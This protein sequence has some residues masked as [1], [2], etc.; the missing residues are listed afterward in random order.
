MKKFSIILLVAL[1]VFNRIGAQDNNQ[2]LQ[3]ANQAFEMGHFSQADTILLS[4][5]KQMKGEYIVKA[6]HLLALSSIYQDKNTEAETY[7]NKLLDVDPYY[8]AYDDPP[9]FAEM[10][11][12]QKKSI[13]TITTASQIAESSDEVPV[14]LTHQI[15]HCLRKD[16]GLSNR[17]WPL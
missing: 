2:I 1:S 9:R 5:L 6:Y 4:N 14:P 7:I 11:E 10:L 17:I 8:T 13:V 3:Q 15:P 12:K 16:R